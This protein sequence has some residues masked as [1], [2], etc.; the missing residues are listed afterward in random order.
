[1]FL[2]PGPWSPAKSFTTAYESIHILSSDHFS[3]YTMWMTVCTT[4]ALPIRGTLSPLTLKT[5]TWVEL[6]LRTVHFCL[7]LI[8]VAIS[9]VNQNWPISSVSQELRKRFY[10][11]TTAEVDMM[12]WAMC[13]CNLF[14]LSS[15]VC[16]AVGYTMSNLKWI[17]GE[18]T[19]PY[20]LMGLMEL[21]S[22]WAVL[23]AWLVIWESMVQHS[24]K[25]EQEF[26]PS[27]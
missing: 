23:A 7:A 14:M 11:S 9:F 8:Y 19:W 25:C 20:G 21:S 4:Q 18:H 17:V 6:Y 16:A 13:S 15:P 26:L 1:M 22:W 5:T 10:F 3:L 12:V 27:V 2:L 24:K